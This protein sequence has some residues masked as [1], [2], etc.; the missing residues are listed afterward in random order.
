[1]TT[2]ISEDYQQLVDRTEATVEKF[3]E[4]A[5]ELREMLGEA[6]AGR[7]VQILAMSDR[8]EKKYEGAKVNLAALT[9]ST[10]LEEIGQMHQ[11]IVSELTDIK[12]TIKHRIR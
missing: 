3:R 11:K 5:E 8:L 1:M 9:P 6:R 4:G 2:E 12:P 10:P 7:K